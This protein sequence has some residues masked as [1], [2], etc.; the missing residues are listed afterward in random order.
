MYLGSKLASDISSDRSDDEHVLKSFPKESQRVVSA[1]IVKSLCDAKHS[2]KILP[3]SAHARW[4]AQ[5][6]GHS[7]TLSLEYA[8]VMNGALAIYSEW[9]VFPFQ[10][11][12]MIHWLF[13]FCFVLLF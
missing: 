6:I 3:T 13:C 9:Y 11:H 12:P 1:S 8:N 4:A 10:T 5:A 7:F 2:A